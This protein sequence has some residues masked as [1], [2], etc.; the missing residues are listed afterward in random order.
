MR[1]GTLGLLG[2]GLATALGCEARPTVVYV[3]GYLVPVTGNVTMD[4][5]PVE[6]AKV[7]FVN[8]DLEG[9][10]AFGMTDAEGR[11]ILRT[12]L[13]QDEPGLPP[14]EQ[15]E[16]AF[17]GQYDVVIV[18]HGPPP[19]G[20]HIG[21]FAEGENLLPEKY[22]YVGSLEARVTEGEPNHFNHFV[23]NLDADP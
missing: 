6:G 5:S 3:T 15:P 4:G 18:K 23:F 13:R 22:S 17:P 14:K 2:F 9:R 11:F 21:P 10:L 12:Y 8:R 7:T 20:S 1:Y 16:G 19:Q